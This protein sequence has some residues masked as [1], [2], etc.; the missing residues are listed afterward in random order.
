VNRQDIIDELTEL[1]TMQES[2]NNAHGDN[3]HN[4]PV[5]DSCA[6]LF[7]YIGSPEH[8]LEELDRTIEIL[9]EIKE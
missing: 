4:C 8:L 5:K 6:R 3:C 2:C 1:R 9:R 7:F